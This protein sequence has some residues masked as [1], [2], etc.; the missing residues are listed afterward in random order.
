MYNY[1]L[2]NMTDKPMF[3]IFESRYDY[4]SSFIKYKKLHKFKNTIS[5]DSILHNI[6]NWLITNNFNQYKSNLFMGEIIWFYSLFTFLEKTNHTIIHC[7]NKT[8]FY[9][10]IEKHKLKWKAFDG[11]KWVESKY[12]FQLPKSQPTNKQ[13]RELGFGFNNNS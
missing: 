9:K 10:M 1:I 12:P 5:H 6:T 7:P 2:I 11:D 3:I 13:R 4:L 8:T